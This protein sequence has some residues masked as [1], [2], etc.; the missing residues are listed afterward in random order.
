MLLAKKIRI[1]GSAGDAE[2]LEFMVGPC[3]ALIAGRDPRIQNDTSFGLCNHAD[4]CKVLIMRVI[5]PIRR[6][7]I[8]RQNPLTVPSLQRGHRLPNQR[9]K[10]LRKIGMPCIDYSTFT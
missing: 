9:P 2:V 1:N 5:P 10:P 8:G 4:V 3:R 6:R 7:A